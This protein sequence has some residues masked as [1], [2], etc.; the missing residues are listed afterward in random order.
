[1]LYSLVQRTFVIALIVALGAPVDHARAED[2]LPSWN[3]GSAKQAIVDFVKATTDTSGPSFVAPDARIATFD[4][5]GTLW[6]EHPMYSQVVYCLDRVP[7]LVQEKPELANVEP[8]KTVLSGDREAMAKLPMPEL[9]KILVATLT[10]MTVEDFAAE[11]GKWIVT[12]KD[13]RWKRAYTELTY[14][15]MRE[16]LA[17]LRANGFK[18]YIVTG[19][20]QDFVRVY[21][22]R[23]YGIPPEQVVGTAGATKYSYDANGKP[24]LTKE[25]KLL[26]N[27]N[28]AGKSEGIHLMIGRRPHAAFGNSTGDRQ[29]LEYTKAGDGARLAMLLL[30]DDAARE[31][32]YGPADNLPD[33]KVGT[34]TQELYDEAKNKGWVVISMKN[35][36]RR[37]F[38][39]ELAQADAPKQTAPDE[40]AR[41]LQDSKKQDPETS[42]EIAECLNQWGPQTQMTKEEWAASCRQTLRYFP[43]SP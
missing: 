33:T 10:G 32:A 30:H 1:M 6:V 42:K 18:T 27:D 16:V 20:G 34:F 29:M 38:A 39:F 7:A 25:P 12:A 43:E 2:Q 21:S 31:Y 9:E 13:A 26:L 23:S 22:E 17:Y 19:G 28:N 8:F 37:V 36:W 15:P 41:I 14:Q 40:A 5:D 35:D 4:Q 24:F 11:V 3:D